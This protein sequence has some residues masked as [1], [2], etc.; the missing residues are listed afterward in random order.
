L[1]QQA[2]TGLGGRQQLL[3]LI[4]ILVATLGNAGLGR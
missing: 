1:R 3:F 4:A 2:L